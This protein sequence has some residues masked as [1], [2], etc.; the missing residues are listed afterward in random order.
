M[1]IISAGDSYA[2]TDVRFD[3]HSAPREFFME[4]NYP[5]PFNPATTV[6]FS[7]PQS[8]TVQ[9]NVF[10]LL[11]RHVATLMDGQVECGTYE[12][13]WNATGN[14]SG[15]YVA[16]LNQTTK[17]CTMSRTMRLMLTK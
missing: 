12:T 11:G 2:L 9:L 10:D 14:A 13:R 5:N 7:I 3:R 15:V 16:R 17:G 1:H 4:Q 6:R 8:G